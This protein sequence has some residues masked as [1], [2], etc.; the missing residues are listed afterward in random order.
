MIG[1]VAIIGLS[2]AAFAF[3][4]ILLQLPR[5][6]YALFAAALT[7]GLTGYA[8]QGSPD[9]AGS[10]TAQTADEAIDGAELIDARRAMFTDR[11]APSF[12]VT[13]ADGFARK[14]QSLDAV[15]LL[16][17]AVQRDPDDAEA[18]LAL[19]N[20]LIA[21]S[22]GEPTPAALIAFSRA[23]AARPG[24]PGPAFFLGLAWFR[25]GRIADARECMAGFAGRGAC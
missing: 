22:D 18:W 8:W 13:L 3:A 1:W 2:I 16:R 14:G 11:G 9:Y 24:H 23:E 7:F 10:P 6:G 21:H 19:A 4:A 12:Y 20:A 15:K 5:S 17:N 25:T